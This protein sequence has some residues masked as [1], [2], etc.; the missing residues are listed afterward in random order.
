MA[1]KVAGARWVGASCERCR[2]VARGWCVACDLDWGGA[3]G[4]LMHRTIWAV[5]RAHFKTWAWN[6]KLLRK[7][8]VTPAQ[9]DALYLLSE[10]GVMMQSKVQAALGVA[11][12]TVSELLKEMARVGLVVRGVRFREGRDVRLTE[13]GKKIVDDAGWLLTE[14]EDSVMNA[15]RWSDGAMMTLV[16]MERWCRYLWRAA[17]AMGFG[18]VYWWMPYED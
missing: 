3:E 15:F 8:K 11:R 10:R 7:L 14:V 6:W 13:A 16:M 9:F 1:P 2:E 18:R 12:S 5:K 17:G 4:F